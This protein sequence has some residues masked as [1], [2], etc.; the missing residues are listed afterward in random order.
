MKLT[1]KKAFCIAIS[2]IKRKHN[3]NACKK[4]LYERHK[5]DKRIKSFKC[6][7]LLFLKY[8]IRFKLLL[9]RIVNK[10]KQL[11]NNK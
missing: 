5:R 9:K 8:K 1:L 11:S 4:E 10:L 6:R 7:E 2:T 3:E